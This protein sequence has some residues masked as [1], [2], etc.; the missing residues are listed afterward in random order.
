VHLLV[1]AAPI[2]GAP[3]IGSIILE[4]AAAIAETLVARQFE[5]DPQLEVR[6]GKRGRDRCLEDAKYHLSY[7]AEAIDAGS[8]ELFIDYLNWAKVM[9]GQRNV[10]AADLVRHLGLMREVLLETLPHDAGAVAGAYIDAGLSVLPN[11]PSEVAT[12]LPA[13]AP[14]ADLAQEYFTLLLNGERHLA[15]RRILD[16]ASSG[17]PVKEIYLHVFQR[18]QREIGRRWQM[19]QLNVAQEHYCTAA[20]QLVMSQLYPMIFATEKGAGNF[21]A[22]CVAGDLH[23][24]GIR[25]VADF[26][27]ME[28]WNTLYLGANT[29][30]AAIVQ[31]L[32]ERRAQVVGISATMSFHVR[33][34]ADLILQVRGEPRCRGVKILVGGYPF[35]VAPDLWR[36]LG[37]DGC[38]HDAQAAVSLAAE[39]V[40][41]G[42]A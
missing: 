34:V 27:E 8:E 4:R 35:M 20:T 1:S 5:R 31:T 21:V 25:M 30:S 15:S 41:G 38:A 9:L 37:A 24:I 2:A 23:E 33:A 42:S 32:V 39:L 3:A 36:R 10:P 7:L 16:A 11:A 14:L 13:D 22:T 28:G 17:T 12:F 19:N 40:A 29:P 26:F 18:A 6:Y